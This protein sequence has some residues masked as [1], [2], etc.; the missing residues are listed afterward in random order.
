MLPASGSASACS[1]TC[2]ARSRAP[3]RERSLGRLV[4]PDEA[5]ALIERGVPTPG[6]TWADLGAG[7]GTFTLALAALIGPLGKVYAVER[8]RS[9]LQTLQRVASSN[10]PR[11]ASVEV[12]DA[13]FTGHL[14]L[15]PL[16]GILA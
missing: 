11:G 7:T 6:G 5:C 1:R 8:D 16:T 2:R 12:V 9:A 3:R 4:T 14:D 10:E 15:P 13:D